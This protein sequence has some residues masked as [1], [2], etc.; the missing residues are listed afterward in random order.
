[1]WEALPIHP[2]SPRR[3]PPPDGDHEGAP[4][5]SPLQR[6]PLPRH[7]STVVVCTGSGTPRAGP[8]AGPV[9]WPTAMHRPSPRQPHDRYPVPVSHQRHAGIRAR[10]PS[11]KRAPDSEGRGPRGRSASTAPVRGFQPRQTPTLA[12]PAPLLFL[13]YQRTRSAGQN[14]L[15]CQP[16]SL[17]TRSERPS[18]QACHAAAR[19][20]RDRCEWKDTDAASQ[21]RGKWFRYACAH[22]IEC[23]VTLRCRRRLCCPRQAELLH[24]Q[25]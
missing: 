13:P 12:E 18:E 16:V 7:H 4:T 1:M 10:R 8:Q 24:G 22:C 19:Q 5:R 11:A 14:A 15:A 23:L 3:A 2:L 17:R 21:A 6:K 25:G 9:R 20:R